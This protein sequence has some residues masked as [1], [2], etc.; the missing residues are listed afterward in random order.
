MLRFDGVY[1]P[2]F[3]AGGRHIRLECDYPST[4]KWLKRCWQEVDG[5]SES[6]DIEDACLSYYK[7]LFPLNPGGILPS[8]SINA[9]SLRL[10][11]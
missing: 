1:S 2:L 10:E 8:P 3:G 11:D 4:F 9:K 5:V 6:I 7:Q